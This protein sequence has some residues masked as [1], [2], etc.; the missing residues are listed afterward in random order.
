MEYFKPPPGPVETVLRCIRPEERFRW[1]LTGSLLAHLLLILGIGFAMPE[2]AERRLDAPLRITLVSSFSEE[3]PDDAKTAAQA[4]S[5]G[6]GNIDLPER[7]TSPP[8][9]RSRPESGP[10]LRMDSYETA[11][12]AMPQRQAADGGTPLLTAPEAEHTLPAGEDGR[13]EARRIVTLRQQLL[14][15]LGEARRAV[16]QGLREKYLGS[17]SVEYE[18]ALYMERWRKRVEEIGNLNYPEQARR[19]RLSGSLV[20]DVGIRPDGRIEEA[21]VVRSS[22]S[23]VLDD[24]AQRIVYLATPFAPFPNSFRG[25]VEVLHLV[26]T[27]EFLHDHLRSE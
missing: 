13:P 18:Y 8:P 22:G 19:L 27:W 2:T 26:R 1:S 12:P 21:R 9:P 14:A 7:L 5:L 16:Q 10:G 11:I 6:G 23:K 15:D 3:R 17:K 4:N 20:L 25:K 24:A